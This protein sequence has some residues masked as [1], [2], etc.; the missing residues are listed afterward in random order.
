MSEINPASA[1][2]DSA[3]SALAAPEKQVAELLRLLDVEKTGDAQFCG[4]RKPGGIGRVFG[5]QVVAQAL[6]SAI[7]TV[8]PKRQVHSLH[9]YFMRPG[10]ED[11]A[12]EFRV[13][14]DFDGGSFSNRRVAAM[15]MGKTILNLVASFHI[16]ETGF[17]HQ[18]EMPDV[19]QPEECI[20]FEQ[21]FAEHKQD[22]LGFL[23]QLASRPSPFDR[24]VIGVPPFFQ[25]HPINEMQSFWFRTRAPVTCNQSKHRTILTYLSDVSILNAAV[26]RHGQPH[27]QTA[28]LDHSVWFHNDVR[29]DDWLLYTTDSPWAGQARGFGRGMI[30]DRAGRL[31]AS[32]AQEGLIRPT[33]DSKNA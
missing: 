10:S 26:R 6:A 14:A 29:A 13:E 20:T 27:L 3:A 4:I 7:Q 31:V 8:D 9:A 2:T 1:T 17:T 18:A 22:I 11:H 24:R 15:Q 23:R 21:Y 32:V 28:S 19:P 33:S 25:T 12:I 30:F 16:E 5:G